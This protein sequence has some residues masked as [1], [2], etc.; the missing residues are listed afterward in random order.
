MV[1]GLLLVVAAVVVVGAVGVVVALILKES[2][3]KWC[4]MECMLVKENFPL[5]P[6]HQVVN[7]S[8]MK[9]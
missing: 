2:G 7:K 6:S 3:F 8:A 4:L 5:L 1:R 9:L